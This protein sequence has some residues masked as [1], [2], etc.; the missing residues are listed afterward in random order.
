[1]ADHLPDFVAATA[2][3]ERRLAELVDLDRADLDYKHEQMADKENGFAF[4]R[5]TYYRRLDYWATVDRS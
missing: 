4:F 1:M 2:A 3:Y 5:G